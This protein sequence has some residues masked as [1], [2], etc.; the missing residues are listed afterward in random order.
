MLYRWTRYPVIDMES[1]VH[2]TWGFQ[3]RARYQPNMFHRE[4][5]GGDPKHRDDSEHA[6][7]VPAPPEPLSDVLEVWF[8]GCHSDVGG[9]AVEDNAPNSLG[10]VSLGWMVKQVILSECG[11]KFD[12][13]ALEEAKIDI[14]PQTL[15]QPQDVL[16]AIHDQLNAKP[17]WW[18]LELMPMKFT[19]Q[20]PDGTWESKWG[21]VLTN[22]SLSESNELLLTVLN[23][24]L[25]I[26][27]GRGRQIRSDQPNFHVSVRQR[28][29]APNLKYKPKAKW[30]PNTEKYV[31]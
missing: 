11:I 12:A 28:M 18:I 7:L 2:L 19:W 23:P 9:G 22:A 14:G 31:E 25:R 4:V 10:N 24:F 30:T 17:L 13:T 26:N 21:Y 8:V 16:A 20:E 6:S 15:P 3:R 1:Y 29:A 5:P 27:F